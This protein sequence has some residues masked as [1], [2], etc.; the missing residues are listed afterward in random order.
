MQC[1]ADLCQTTGPALAAFHAE[2]L[3]E[4]D[5]PSE[6]R[7]ERLMAYSDVGID[8][9]G[10]LQS[11]VEKPPS[12]PRWVSMNCWRLG[13]SIFES[14]GAIEP[15]PRGELELPSAV[16]HSTEHLGQAYRALP[17]VGPVL[18]LSS[19]ADVRRVQARLAPIEVLL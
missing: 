11:I 6:N 2:S 3:L 14:C 9:D 5:L 15:S 19:R 1:L 12:P 4:P 13:P 18:D 17:A 8:D 16:L 10:W 7:N